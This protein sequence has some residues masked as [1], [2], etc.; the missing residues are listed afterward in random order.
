VRNLYAN[1]GEMAVNLICYSE[2]EAWAWLHGEKE[3]VQ[4]PAWD[5]EER[6]KS[7][8]DKRRAFQRKIL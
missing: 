2:V 7:H 3:L 1:I 8:A 6:R 5:E 4:R